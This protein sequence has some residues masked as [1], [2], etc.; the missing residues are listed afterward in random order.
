MKEPTKEELNAQYEFFINQPKP[1]P[2]T[3]D[4]VLYGNNE[5]FSHEE[6]LNAHNALVKKVNRTWD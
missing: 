5:D 4:E 3:I 1:E 6:R 2:P